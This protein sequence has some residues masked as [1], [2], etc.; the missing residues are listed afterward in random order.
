M[1]QLFYIFMAVLPMD[2]S[3]GSRKPTLLL[4]YDSAMKANDYDVVSFFKTRTGN[5]TVTL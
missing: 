3:D 1:K 4:S 2:C 5:I